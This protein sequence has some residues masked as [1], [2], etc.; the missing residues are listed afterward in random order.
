[1]AILKAS[2]AGER[3]PQRLAKLR[4]PPCYHTEDDSAKALPGTWQAAPLCA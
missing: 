2:L 3:A 4:N 1:M